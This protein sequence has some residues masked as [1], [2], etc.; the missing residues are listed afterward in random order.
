MCG[1]Q[2]CVNPD[3]LTTDT[4]VARFWNNIRKGEECW[5]WVGAKNHG[6]GVLSRGGRNGANVLAHRMS[7]EI[8]CGD[9][10]GLV[11]CHRCDNPSC[12]RPDHLF[13]GTQMDNMKDMHKK[14]RNAYGDA[15]AS[16]GTCHPQAVLNEEK[17]IEARIRKSKG[18]K[19]AEIAGDMGVSESAM[20]KA[21]N[22]YTWKHVPMM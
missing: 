10:G 19:V 1:N 15:V 22:G 8:N 11:V 17:V 14:G 5:E 18:E 3:H 4:S 21:V 7:Y 20:K 9:P 16:K 2:M 6:Y 13:L 12:V